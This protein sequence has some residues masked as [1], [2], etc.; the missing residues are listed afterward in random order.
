MNQGRMKDTQSA[1]EYKKKKSSR[2]HGCLSF[3]FCVLSGGVLCDR[4]IPRPEESCCV[5]LNVIMKTSTGQGLGSR[6]LLR[7]G[8]IYIFIY[9]FICM[10]AVY[11][12]T[13]LGN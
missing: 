6:G 12:T 13:H 1:R 9:L 8:N 7:F 3:E 4:P 10:H 2:G 11:R 5:S